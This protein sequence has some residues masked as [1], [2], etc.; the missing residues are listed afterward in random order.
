MDG[1]PYLVSRLNTSGE[2]R[3]ALVN[4]EASEL[5]SGANPRPKFVEGARSMH[6]SDGLSLPDRV[7]AF[8]VP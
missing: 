6:L 4:P 1:S 8:A 7:G 5:A 2:D 3:P